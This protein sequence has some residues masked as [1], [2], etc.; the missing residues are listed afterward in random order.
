MVARIESN[1]ERQSEHLIMRPNAIKQYWQ[2]KMV[3][4]NDKMWLCKFFGPISILTF[5]KTC[6]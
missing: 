3:R 1:E 4:N 5:I 6:L 2:L